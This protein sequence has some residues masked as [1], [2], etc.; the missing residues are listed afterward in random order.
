[1]PELYTHFI[2]QTS[3]Q[4]AQLLLAT[5]DAEHLAQV[6]YTDQEAKAILRRVG[7]EA[8]RLVFATL[9]ERVTAEAQAEGF[10]IERRPSIRVD[11]L[12]G[13]IEIESPYL[14][15]K[16]EGRRPV[17]ERLKVSHATRTPAVERA[18]ADFGAEESFAHASIRFAEH[19]GFCV[20]ASTVGRVV[21]GVAREAADYL[22]EKL[23]SAEAEYEKGQ[24]VRRGVAELLAELD[25]CEIRT[26]QCETIRDG[27]TQKVIKRVRTLEWREVRVG[28][29]GRLGRLKRTYVARL[30]SYAEVG[31]DLFRA[32]ILEGLTPETKVIGVGDGGQ[33][34]REELAFQFPRLQFILDKSHVVSHLY[35][36]AEA[37]N[38]KERKREQ[39]VSQKI[40]QISAGQVQKVV[41]ELK[42]KAERCERAGRLRAYLE[43]FADALSY[44][45]FK[46]AGYPVG[47]GEVES[48]HRYIPQKRLKI[49]G[50]SW[51]AETVNQMLALRLIRAN[52][53]WGEFWQQRQAK[54]LAA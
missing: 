51:K 19:Y 18:L 39:W 11:T 4:L 38:Y 14:W 43:R 25:G 41:K 21:E 20:G 52:G 2:H 47:S 26:V 32:A 42:G 49:A 44:D 40:E 50:A 33:G 12:F 53:W 36:T 30:G 3:Q 15:R 1:M 13:A 9:A 27:Q 17:T 5:L 7:Q 48:A 35:E 46:A 45:R 23:A 16:G 29:A 31:R 34:L 24:R 6:Q 8:M 22:A 54:F 28:L 37:L 10:T